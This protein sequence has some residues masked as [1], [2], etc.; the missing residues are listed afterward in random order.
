MSDKVKK[1]GSKKR[2]PRRKP[3]SPVRVR[4]RDK[5]QSKKMITKRKIHVPTISPFM[6]VSACGKRKRRWFPQRL[7]GH[8]FND[9]F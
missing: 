6:A 1:K 7:A 5:K 2:Q 9:A 3:L 4:Q 8:T